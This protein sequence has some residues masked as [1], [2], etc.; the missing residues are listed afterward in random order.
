MLPLGVLAKKLLSDPEGRNR[1]LVAVVAVVALI[2]AFTSGLSVSI[3]LGGGGGDQALAV[4]STI[5]PATGEEVFVDEDGNVIDDEQLAAA[6]ITATRRSAASGARAPGARTAAGG[7]GARGG[8]GAGAVATGAPGGPAAPAASQGDRCAGAALGATDQGVTAET[9]KLGVLV[10]NLNEL[11]VAGFPVG[12]SGDFDAIM[13]AWVNE[14]NRTGVACRQVTWVKRN[15]DVTSADD[16]QRV[17]REMTQDEQVFSVV[18]PGG[19][20][21]VGQLCIAKDAGVPLINAEPEP[22]EWYAQSA[23]YLWTLSTSKDRGHINHVRY[24]VEHG[25]LTKEHKIGVIYD[26]VPHVAP[27]TEKGLLPE[28]DRQGLKPAKVFKLSS[29]VEQA[30]NQI[31]QVVVD[32]RLAGVDFVFMPM[33]LIY[34][35]QF[36]TVAEQQSY[37]PQYTESDHNFGCYDFTTDTYP[38]RQYDGTLCVTATDA[39]GRVDLEEYGKTHPFAKYADEVYF[40][41]HEGGY[42]EDGEGS[43]GWNAQKALHISVGSMIR[44]WQQAADRV[45]PDLT[46]AAWGAAMGQTG[47]FDQCVCEHPLRFEPD[48]WDGTTTVKGLR[49]HA[50][51]GEGF[52]ARTYREITRPQPA[53]AQKFTP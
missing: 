3:E 51:A 16:M 31:N 6:G 42:H 30:L 4:T 36:M 1:L 10:P 35:T 37:R 5:D 49:W 26:G 27:A 40:R 53:Y 23:P 11:E 48:K 12:L 34:K 8:A 25:H 28:L 17:C 50:Q 21:S 43:D 39:V 13:Q 20:D 47:D 14:L 18:T 2:G 32:F 46:R 33:N 41:T 44:A 9:I 15:F 24:L 19:Y 45:G 52:D 38:A 22:A 7:G 29:D